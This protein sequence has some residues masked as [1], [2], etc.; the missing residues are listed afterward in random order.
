MLL[1]VIDFYGNSLAQFLT[2]SC[3]FLPAVI[4][5]YPCSEIGITRFIDEI[6]RELLAYLKY[7]GEFC[8]KVVHTMV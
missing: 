2:Q 8:V 7:F 6:F 3:R 4:A 5:L 1:S